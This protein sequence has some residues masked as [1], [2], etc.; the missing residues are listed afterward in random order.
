MEPQRAARLLGAR[1]HVVGMS[2]SGK[3]TL[4]RC[5]AKAAG[6]DL[7]DLDALNWL[8]GWVALN[9]VDKPALERRFR[10]ATGGK[11]WVSAGSYRAVAQR[12]FW[13]RLETIVWLDMPVALCLGRMLRRSWR[14]WRSRELLGA[15]IGSASGRT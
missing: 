3:T 10:A 8:P 6:A 14:S 5:L 4:A 9:E 7:V 2:G 12:A 13:P 15:P 11:R 1:V